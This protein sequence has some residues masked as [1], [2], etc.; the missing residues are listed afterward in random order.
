VSRG[1]SETPIQLA[2][3]LSLPLDVAT[4]TLGIL[5][6]KDGG[7]SYAAMLLVEQM[8]KARLP[9]VA[10]DPVGV[11]WGLRVAGKGPG[12]PIVILGGD[13]GDVPIEPGSGR[14]VADFVVAERQPVVIDFRGFQTKAEQMRFSLDFL[15]RLYERNR[16]VLHVVID[17]ADELAPQK[18]FGEET[19]VLRAV[20]VLVRR[21]RARGLGCTLIT[22]RPA[23]L[24][25][26]VLTQCSTLVVGRMMAPQDRKAVEA[27]VE[28]HGTES[29][30]KQ[31]MGSLATLPKFDKWVWAP[32]RGVF[33]RVRIAE[34]TTFDSSA[35][36]KVGIKRAEPKELA[37]IDLSA[38]RGRLAETIERAK[39]DDPNVLKKRIAELQA[40]VKKSDAAPPA[41][42]TVI[43][44][45]PDGLAEKLGAL[46]KLAREL[47]D[48]ASRSLRYGDNAARAL[49]HL[50]SQAS[51]SRHVVSLANDAITLVAAAYG[52]LSA[53]A[54][55]KTTRVDA[56][57][58]TVARPSLPASQV[59]RA[60]IVAVAENM[61]PPSREMTSGGD[62]KLSSGEKRI[63]GRLRMARDGLTSLQLGIATGYT[64]DG[65]GFRNMLS[66]MRTLGLVLG[67]N[68]EV[69]TLTVAGGAVAAAQGQLHLN[70][71]AD[72]VTEW[73]GQLGKAE[74]LILSCV[75]EE[76]PVDIEVVAARTSY[77]STGGG[78]RN[79]LSRLRSLGLIEGKKM[80]NIHPIF[81]STVS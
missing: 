2:A 32:A 54:H 3:D 67:G 36:P 39:A 27:W 26:N 15:T 55:G 33:R 30:K 60:A 35:T 59:P 80:L 23:V 45:V 77:E 44:R 8:V 7:K 75:W 11:F 71:G 37:E 40:Q 57:A 63:L 64:W 79:A 73:L 18:P 53:E 70:E 78:F 56:K 58:K 22:Q 21:G 69:M 4:D 42:P 9:V 6:I 50:T 28:A 76:G 38:L 10:I 13:H 5:A 20:E 24:N 66:H 74:R 81:H 68:S 17:E 48:T 29:D 62:V 41:A 51:E 47:L 12:L 31:M 46:E 72:L 1:P 19:R 43:E 61:M 34:R 16:D 52:A 49:E 14:A 65:G 25:K